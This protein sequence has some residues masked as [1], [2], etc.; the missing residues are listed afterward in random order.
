MR[1]MHNKQLNPITISESDV[2]TVTESA[3]FFGRAWDG[4]SGGWTGDNLTSKEA[5]A[6]GV[7]NV[8]VGSVIGGVV[9]RKRAERNEPAWLGF[10]Y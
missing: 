2:A 3:S 9:A 8:L 7:I 4:F 6:A 5:F 10:L 1:Q